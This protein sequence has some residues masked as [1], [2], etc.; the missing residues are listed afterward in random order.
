MLIGSIK[1]QIDTEGRRQIR[2]YQIDLELIHL[3]TNEKVWIDTHKIKK[4]IQKALIRP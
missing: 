3:E 2:Y 4:Y 1:S